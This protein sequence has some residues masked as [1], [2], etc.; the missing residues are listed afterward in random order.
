MGENP[1]KGINCPL[2]RS[3]RNIYKIVNRTGVFFKCGKCV[4]TFVVKPA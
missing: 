1:N 2:C 4:V 3:G